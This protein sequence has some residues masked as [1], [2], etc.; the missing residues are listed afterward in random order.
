M[1]GWEQG[2]RKRKGEKSENNKRWV[3]DRI[4]KSEKARIVE[5][6]RGK[7]KERY[8]EGNY[9]EKDETMENDKEDEGGGRKWSI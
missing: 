8:R 7:K 5:K 4:I 3:G 6:A 1:K 9:V 2:Q